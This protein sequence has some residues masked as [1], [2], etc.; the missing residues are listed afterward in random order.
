MVKA[1]DCSFCDG[2]DCESCDIAQAPDD[3]EDDP[4]EQCGYGGA[5][6]YHLNS[7]GKAVW[8]CRECLEE[9]VVSDEE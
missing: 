1:T 8:L 3:A 2:L 5:R 7:S 9:M 4:C 6:R